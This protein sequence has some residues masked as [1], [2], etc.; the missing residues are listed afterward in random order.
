MKS[1]APAT[2]AQQTPNSELILSHNSTKA[3]G[4]DA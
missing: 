2:E 4:A 3:G 1:K